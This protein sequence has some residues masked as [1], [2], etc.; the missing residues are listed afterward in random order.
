MV[1]GAASAQGSPGAL[2]LGLRIDVDTHDGMKRGVP[3][4][5][6]ILARHGVR[7]TF[8]LSFGPDRAG[9]AVLNIFRPGF[10]AKMLRTRAP[11]VYGPRTLLSGTLLPARRIALALPEI[12]RRARDSGHEVGVHCWDHRFWQDRLL[13]LPPA[14]VAAELDRARDAFVTVFGAPPRTF[15]APAWLASEV[16]LLHQESYG[17]A[18]GSDCRGVEPFVPVLAGRELVTPQVPATQIGRAHV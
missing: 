3:R 11:S 9:L 18:Y 5:L 4:L 13:R 12:A 14:R 16:S 2:R 8:Y 6:E 10:L 7:G 17:L 1:N 15:A